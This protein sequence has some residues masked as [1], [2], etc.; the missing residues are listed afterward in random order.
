MAGIERGAQ[1][2][3]RCSPG[4]DFDFDNLPLDT[5]KC[6]L[7]KPNAE[8]P[9]FENLMRQKFLAFVSAFDF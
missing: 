4:S 5:A 6:P 3:R 2:K 8:Q 9:Y 1:T 7:R